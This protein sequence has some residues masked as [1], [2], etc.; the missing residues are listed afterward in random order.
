[1][2][3]Q[4]SI[5]Y[6]LIAVDHS[7]GRDFSA[8]VIGKA[9]EKGFTVIGRQFG[10]VT[11][12]KKSVADTQQIAMVPLGTDPDKIIETTRRLLDDAYHDSKGYTPGDWSGAY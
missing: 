7:N 6:A 12:Q 3:S 11:Q 1:M 4:D 9:G 5:K 8:A 10:K 2:H